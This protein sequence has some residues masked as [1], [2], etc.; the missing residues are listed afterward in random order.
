MMD[1]D[2]LVS[3]EKFVEEDVASG[4]TNAL[5]PPF[6]TSTSARRAIKD[7]LK[8]FIEAA[9]RRG[10]ALDH[11]LFSGPPGLGKTT[12]AHII[13]NEMGVGIETTSGP[14]D[15]TSPATWPPSS[16]TSRPGDVLFIDEIHRL[17]PVVEEILY[18]AMEDYQ[19]DILIGQGPSARSIKIDL[20]PLH[21]GGRHD[22]LRAPHG[23]AARPL[24]RPVP[25]RVLRPEEL[26]I[27][28]ARSA[29]ILGIGIDRRGGLGDRAP[30]P[31]HPAHR[32]PPAPAGARLR[33][34]A[35]GGRRS[36]GRSPTR[37]SAARTWTRGVSTGW[38]AASWRTIIRLFSGG[39][40]GVETIAAAIGEEKDTLEDVYEPY[41]IQQGYLCRTARGR[42]ATEAAYGHS[43]SNDP[44]KGSSC[45][46]GHDEPF[47]CAAR[48]A[49]SGSGRGEIG[50]D[51]PIS[52]QSMTNTDTRDV[53]ATLAQI[54]R[55]AAAGCEIVR[56]AVPDEEAARALRAIRA[57]AEV[58]AGGRHPFRPPPGAHGAGM[59][60]WTGCASIP[61][62][63][64]A[65]GR[66]KRWCGP[67]RSA[68]CP[69][70]SGSTPA[71]WRRTCWNAHGAPTPEALVES[72]LRHVR[73]LEDLGLR[74]RSR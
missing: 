1:E 18:P 3:A 27:I 70:A 12:L 58:A 64:A 2:R 23:A 43:A 47:P 26:K 62:T 52:V 63:S 51:A 42:V 21:A 38:T 67:P 45:E 49:R 48:P 61:A 40:V 39:P 36:T 59:P 11:V 35:H 71:A 4:N 56:L 19:L 29:G 13:A 8:V 7:N 10:E 14:V 17:S 32:Q 9:K 72:A 65:G 20:P 24:R 66:S 74:P 6:W 41:L 16:P 31:G 34:G 68:A 57:G 15:R 5:R 55:L 73:M 69:S 25:P 33:R 54:R 50:G 46:Y 30:Q 22:A 28:V 60:G 53:A 44:A 37:R